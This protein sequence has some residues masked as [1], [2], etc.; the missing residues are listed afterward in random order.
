[1]YKLLV[2]GFSA[3]GIPLIS[4]ILQALPQDYPLPV[5]VV[6]H[7]PE[8]KESLLANL[9]DK[10]TPLTVSMAL[11]KEAILSG[12]V[13]LAPPGYHLLVERRGT[14]VPSFALSV[15]E[16]VQNVRPSIDVLF[17][18]AAEVFETGL[19]AVLLSGAN[20][21]GAQGMVCVK[22]LG[23][24]GIVLSPKECEFNTMA[25]AALQRVQVDYVVGMEEI[26]SL[27]HSAHE[28]P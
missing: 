16:P 5:V 13:Y 3:G 18:S 14:S 21:D 20:S 24:L 15:D 27:L 10:I 28:R 1:M 7:L 11:D 19:I 12:H 2:I 17:E 25:K 26:V 23:G 9:L 22:Q 8:K 4:H 6:S